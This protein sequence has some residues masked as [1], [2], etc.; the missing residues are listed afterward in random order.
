M[1]MFGLTR[2]FCGVG[3]WVAG[4]CVKLVGAIRFFNLVFGRL[5]EGCCG[6]V[7]VHYLA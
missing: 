5:L 6:V 7:L 4:S 1:V 2:W 3:L